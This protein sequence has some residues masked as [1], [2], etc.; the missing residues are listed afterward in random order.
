MHFV[1]ADY[2][3]ED[4][5]GSYNW[6]AQYTLEFLNAYLKHDPTAMQFL[7]RTPTENDVPKHLM[8]VNLRQASS[9][10]G[11]GSVPVKK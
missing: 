7:K 3:L 4:G 5:A 11:E 2:S 6:M 8:A 9:K 1:P 10:A